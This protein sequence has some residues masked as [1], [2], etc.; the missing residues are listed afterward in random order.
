VTTSADRLPRLLALVP[1]L[2]GR[3]GVPV[4]EVAAD[5]GVTEAQLRRD[6]Q[7][8]W[9]CGLPGHG[10]GD[11]IDLSFEGETVTVTYDAGMSRPLRLSADEAL[12]IVVALRTLAD[13][14]GLQERAAVERALAKVES[15]AGGAA[16]VAGAVAVRV[17]RSDRR[18]AEARRALDQGRALHLSYYVAAR[19]ETTER[20]VDPVQLR[21]VEGRWYLEAWCRRAEAMRLFRLD[22]ID[23]LQ[24]LDEPSRPP[25][26]AR[27]RDLSAGV[28]QPAAEHPLVTL[29]LGPAGRWVADYYPCESV[30]NLPDGGV[31]VSLR[32]ADPTW[33]RR[34]VLGFGA[35]A[36]VLAPEWL[37][38]QVRTE[39][40][41]ALAGY[42][43]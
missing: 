24:V 35:A 34:L 26:A 41:E 17:E 36:E 8:L 40:R 43:L 13:V 6:L 15:A 7:L 12:A 4:A 5:F 29:R 10:P 19:D 2:L 27:P 11:L 25:A 42:G 23:V 20:D 21:S 31:L 22:R 38:E 30:R 33:V 9:V 16:E 39:A 37:A 1:Y 3:P 32:V 14:P 28:Y 18:L